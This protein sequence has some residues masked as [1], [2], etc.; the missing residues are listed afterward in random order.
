MSRD[1]EE[2]QAQFEHQ[3]RATGYSTE[4][5]MQRMEKRADKLEA[6][7]KA[8]LEVV[9]EVRNQFGADVQ[10]MRFVL[11]REVTGKIIEALAA[12]AITLE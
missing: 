3:L 9:G 1:A 7:N 12:A 11:G 10:P 2:Q 8:L 6:Q 5:A 4:T